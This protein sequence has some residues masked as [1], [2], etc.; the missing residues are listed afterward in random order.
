MLARAALSSR[1]SLLAGLICCISLLGG[2]S[3]H[4][5]EV[6]EAQSK[7]PAARPLVLDAESFKHYVDDFNQ[8][9]RE[10]YVQYISNSAAWAFL[11]TNIP[12][13]DCPD[14][15]LEAIYYF[16]WWT[17]RKAIKQ[18]SSGFVITEFLPPVGWA[19]KE[20]TID[21]AAGHHL[22]EGRWLA[23]PRFLDDY[24]LFWFRKGGN[25]RSY[26]FWAA[27]SIWAR[28][29]VTGDDRLIKTLVPDLVANYEAWEQDHRDSNGLF[30]QSDD[31]D[32]ME[33]SIGGSGYRATINSYMYGD[34]VAIAKL[35]ARVG[36]D[37]LAER[38]RGK[39]AEIKRLVQ[40]RLWNP[41][42]QFFEVLPRGNGQRLVDVRELHGFTPWY[43]ELPDPDKSVAWRQ[44]MDTAG[45]FAPFGL[46]TAE[47]R[48]PKFTISYTGHE[49]QWNGPSWPF[50]TSITLTALANLLDD[51]Q[52]NVITRDDYFELLKIYVQSQHRRREDGAVVPWIDEN[53]NPLSGDWIARTRL[54]TWK[55]G[56]TWDAAQ[57]GEERGKDYNHSTFCDLV[58]NGLIGLR[59]TADNTV[60]V[61]PLLPEGRWAY[62]CLDQVWC[63]GHW[64]T[65]LYDR[66]GEHYHRG[67]GL[68][69]FADGRVIATAD[70]LQRVAGKLPVAVAQN[71]TAAATESAPAVAADRG[72]AGGWV[73]YEH[74]PVMGGKYGTC[75]DI[76]VL[77]ENDTYRMWL[78]WR[79]K[80]SIALVESKDGFQWSEPP[81]V[82]LGPR[83]ESGWEDEVNRPV[84]LKKKDGYHLW[85]T[86]QAAGHSWIG[87]ATSTDGIAWKR[88]SDKPVLSAER[89]WEKVAVMCPHVMWDEPMR[90]YRMWY[91]GGEQYEPNAIGYATSPDGLKWTKAAANPVFT[92]DPKIPWEQQRVTGCQVLKHGDWFYM[93]YIGFRDE[94]HAQIG[95][96][97]S[98]DGLTGWQRHP[99]NPIVR[100]GLAHD[101]KDDWDFDACYK[102]CA[103]FDGTKW[104]LWYNGRHGGLEQIG[105][106]MHDGEELG[107]GPH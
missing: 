23:D 97:R 68:R 87:Y 61:N 8:H 99:A 25:P 46:T 83:K 33:Q 58:I 44:A 67:K 16:R 64:L 19:G 65:I 66:T 70:K 84:V 5:E 49:C 91:S 42:A 12:L 20:N 81:R 93:F 3:T 51:Y 4:A 76:S 45:F 73:K 1:P 43:F 2:S 79:P 59:P 85:Y 77:K 60:V 105:V 26:S 17:F 103:I 63:H 96:A 102:P 10:L 15:E 98:R 56:K 86:G 72:A 6:A 13:L 34:A 31:R 30:W 94:A 107:F 89:P 28:F 78:S 82:V 55:D 27:D 75:F 106:A 36:R 7:A 38:F 92:P 88:M 52:Q 11:K 24:S 47:R 69:I 40:E 101:G 39:A 41:R 18:T 71:P 35:A 37:E 21:C 53:L 62:F 14:K 104:L 74:N 100:A 9:D 54:K 57:G 90:L 29:L 22:R 95:L 80:Q 48:H 50:A 32:G